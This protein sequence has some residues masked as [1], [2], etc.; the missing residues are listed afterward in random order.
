MSDDSLLYLLKS[1]GPQTAPQVGEALGMTAA[2]A[3][4][5]LAKLAGAGLVE[6]EDRKAGRGRPRRYWHL[7]DAGHARFPD[8]HADLTLE[9]LK[10]TETL[11][12]REGLDRLIAHRE[13]QSLALYR[14]RLAGSSDIR[15]RVAAL[16][17]IRTLEGY[18][19]EWQEDGPGAFVLIENH[20]PVCAAATACQ[21]LCRS[22]LAI[23]REVLGP[24][25]EVQRTD[26]I[27]AGA[28]RCAYTITPRNASR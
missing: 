13:A 27:L 22:E 28:R 16:A 25:V 10:A 17:E 4:Q 24:D 12:G 3:Q 21:G 14:D 11:F 1:R 23:F 15:V 5:R 6:P 20:C 8:R 9:I 19:A 7:T 2:G 26:H 18:M